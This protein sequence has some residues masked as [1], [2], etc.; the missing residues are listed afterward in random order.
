MSGHRQT[1]SKGKAK[2]KSKAN[3]PKAHEPQ[4]RPCVIKRFEPEPEPKKICVYQTGRELGKELGCG[5][6]GCAYE[7]D[8]DSNNVIKISP[9]K[10]EQVAE[11]WRREACLGSDLGVMQVGPK[12]VDTFECGAHGYIVMERLQDASRLPDRTRV[13]EGKKGDEVDNLSRMPIEVQIGFINV[14][15]RMISASYIHMDNHLENLGFIGG[16]PIAFDFGFTQH[17]TW[18]TVRD[19]LFA[20][21]FSLFQML[22]KCPLEQI[23]ETVLWQVASAIVVDTAGDV[24]D[25]DK[26]VENSRATLIS[27]HSKLTKQFKPASAKEQSKLLALFKKRAAVNGKNADVYVGSWCYAVLLQHEM[28]ERFDDGSLYDAIYKIRR[29]EPY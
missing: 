9:L 22:E 8:P 26:I 28:D 17:R 18:N 6:Q 3:Q 11:K 19:R 27:T 15:S 5:E 2:T 7:I 4:S 25:V 12:I 16:R 21:A 24:W 20:L 1:R 29:N 23:R 10:D 13:R 14:L